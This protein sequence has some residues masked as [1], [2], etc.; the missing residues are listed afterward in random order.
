MVLR[1]L[2]RRAYTRSELEKALR[3]KGVPDDAGRR[4]LDRFSELRLIAR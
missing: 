1:M 4:V 2:D 3:K